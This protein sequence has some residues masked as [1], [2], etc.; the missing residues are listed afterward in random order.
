MVLRLGGAL[1]VTLAAIAR[2]VAAGRGETRGF[3][4]F[5]LAVLLTL[6]IWPVTAIGSTRSLALGCAIAALTVCFLWLER[7]PLR[8]GLGVAVLGG[9][10][11]AGALPLSM[12]T[13]RDGPWFDY[14]TWAE[15]LATP[16]SV[17]FDWEHSYGPMRW[18]RE[19]REMLRIKTS[20]AQYWKLEN[21][22][23]FDGLRWVQRGVPDP[24][25]PERGGRPRAELDLQAAVDRPRARHRPR[26][27]RRPVRRRRH[28]R[29]RRRRRRA[30]R[31]RPSRPAPGRPTAS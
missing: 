29:R 28:H 5:A 6:V 13:D 24:F 22:E 11:L 25:G 7:L 4:F 18:Q 15:G 26:P 8:P 12:A 21:L 16:A 30:A 31:P 27:A 23:D 2:R 10:A 9:I 14:R 3:P 17:R 19:G 20:R 1:F